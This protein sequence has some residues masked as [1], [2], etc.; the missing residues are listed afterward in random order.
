VISV[1]DFT[2]QSI[3]EDS[4]RVSITIELAKGLAQAT[5]LVDIKNHTNVAR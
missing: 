2:S 3:F 4:S 5:N 1:L